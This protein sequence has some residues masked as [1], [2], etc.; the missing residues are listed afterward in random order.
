MGKIGDLW[1]RLGLKSEDYKKGIKEANQQTEGFGAKLGKMK[2]GALAV[3]AAVG[4]SVLAFAKQMKEATNRVGDAWDMFIAKSTAGWNTFIQSLSAW[5][6]DNFIGRIREARAAAEGLQS[7]LDAE[8]EINNSIRL[9]KAAMAEELA[10]LEILAKNVAKPYEER[11]KAAQKYLSMVKPIYDQELALANKLLDAQQGR[12]LAGTGLTDSEQ[13]RKDLSQFLVDYGKYEDLAASLAFVRNHESAAGT[14]KRSRLSFEEQVALSKEYMAHKGVIAGYQGSYGTDLLEL[15]KVYENLR[16]DKDTMPLVDALIR[17]GQ[18]AA[19]F[20]QETK[21][22]QQALNAASVKI[23]G[24]ATDIAVVMEAITQLAMEDIDNL[25]DAFEDIELEIPPI[26]TSALDAG[27]AAIEENAAKYEEALAKAAQ[28]NAMLEGAIVAT[29]AN[30]FQA[31]SDL[32]LGIEGA[33]AETVLAALM[34]P[35]AD[36]AGQLGSMLITEG[37]A[38]EA[39]K[40]SLSSLQGGVAI[41]AGA[42]LLA[43]SAAMKSGIKALAGNQA[44]A[45]S[46]VSYGGAM[47]NPL[48]NYESTLTVYVEGKISGSDILLA[49]KKTQSKWNR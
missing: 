11:A 20:N 23:G 15:S 40:T 12:W 33:N 25:E 42:A 34:Q 30:A 41:A 29:T 6:W 28:A 14:R 21:K 4:A 2:A 44:G 5:N 3:W 19:A 36:T 32:L 7:A 17:A 35:F 13:T 43:V 31:F 9:Q 22:M 1:V 8:F 16:G 47:G 24:D 10:E 45:G 18:A 46:S 49:G 38:I 26:D 27:L 39:F 37:L 48:E